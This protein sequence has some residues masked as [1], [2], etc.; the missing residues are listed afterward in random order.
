MSGPVIITAGGTGGHMFPALALAGELERRGRT[1]ALA[2]DE[3]GA[4]YLPEGMDAFKIR[5]SSPSGS[6]GKRTSGIVNLG[7]GLLQSWWWLKRQNPIAVAAFGSYASVPVGVAAN[8]GEL[9][10][11]SAEQVC[12]AMDAT[13]GQRELYF[14]YTLARLADRCSRADGF[15]LASYRGLN[16]AIIGVWAVNE[17]NVLERGDTHV[18]RRLAFALDYAFADLEDLTA[19]I[20]GVC[21]DLAQH[22]T[23]HLSFMCDTRAPEYPSLHELADAEDQFALHTLP[24]IVP[25]LQAKTIYCDAVY[26]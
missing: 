22:G 6:L 9:V 23:T 15:S 14:P 10:R 13:H 7:L 3:R 20:R 16:T 4:R 1:V 18:E 2:C 25:D 17:R 24:W 8:V 12:A 11:P 26:S 5:A 19:L 21:M